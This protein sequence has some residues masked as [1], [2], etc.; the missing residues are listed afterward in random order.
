MF[1]LRFL[2]WLFGWVR[3]EAEGGFPERF[4][5]LAAR[6]G[7]SLW[8]SGR[9]GV[10]LEASCL[11]RRYKKLRP[12]A[13]KTG[14]RMRVKS[15]HGVPFFCHRYRARGGVV[16][17][18][19]LYAVLLQLLSQ[20]IWVV[21]ISGSERVPE[22][23]IRTVVEELGVRKGGRMK[24]LDIASL[25]IA[26]L[27][28]LPDLVFLTVNPE[29]CIA[30]VEVSDR[31]PA[32]ELTD[33][34][35]ASNLKAARDGRILRMDVYSG[36]AVAQVGDAVVEGMLLVSGV[37]DTK[38]GPVL[39]RSSAKI[40][41]QT[42]RTLTVEIPLEETQMLPSGEV[43]VR[44]TLELFQFGIPLYT[45]GPIEEAYE[46]VEKRH[47]FVA[48]GLEMPLGLTNRYY[49]LLEPTVLR[50][51]EEEAAALA[52]EQLTSQESEE[53]AGADIQER[54][55]TSRVQDGVYILTAAYT[56]VEDIGRE[57]VLLVDGE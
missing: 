25:Q 16:V 54:K 48:N 41:A 17:G 35:T 52:A 33:K 10:T 28:K 22:E 34:T 56:C 51:T 50:R 39:R 46:L 21:D 23:E 53:L 9:H 27:Q 31:K 32:P 37:V 3:L 2:R 11:A 38:V 18:V 20:R 19:V 49:H 26:A 7:V 29:G 5:N 13:R 15:K 14:V 8:D 57:E 44:P 47:P 43:I 30:H 42:S 1:I 36:Q 24:E 12:L 55:L 6:A 45:D 40:L 4:L